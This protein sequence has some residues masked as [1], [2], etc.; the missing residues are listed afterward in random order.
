MYKIINQINDLKFDKLCTPT[1]SDIKG[2]TEY[3]LYVE[4][5]KTNVRKFTFSNRIAPA[6]NALS[7]T[8]E[9]APNIHNFKDRLDR[10]PKLIMNT[11]DDDS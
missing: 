7:L 10:D 4:Y 1:K 9:S 3:K 8:T 6:W 11:S 2:N 5:S